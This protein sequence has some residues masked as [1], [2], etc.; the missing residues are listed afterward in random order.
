MCLTKG[1][2]KLVSSRAIESICVTTLKSW[3]PAVPLDTCEIN[4]INTFKKKTLHSNLSQKSIQKPIWKHPEKNDKRLRTVK[5]IFFPSLMRNSTSP[6][7][8]CSYH[9]WDMAVDEHHM[10]LPAHFRNILGVF[11][12]LPEEWQQCRM[13]IITYCIWPIKMEFIY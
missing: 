6:W 1:Q 2:L 3:S 4:W 7:T 13:F 11:R 10:S 8:P 9:G 5:S 12:R